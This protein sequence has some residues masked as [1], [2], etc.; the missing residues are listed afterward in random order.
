MTENNDSMD[1]PFDVI[2]PPP[3][4]HLP[5]DVIHPPPPFERVHPP[6]KGQQY[7]KAEAMKILHNFKEN[8]EKNN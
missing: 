6:A 3:Q 1:L 8:E 5:F 4:K 7:G 2:H